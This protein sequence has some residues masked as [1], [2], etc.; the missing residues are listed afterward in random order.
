MLCLTT[1]KNLGKEPNNMWPTQNF[2]FSHK[3]LNLKKTQNY[4]S[5]RDMAFHIFT[6]GHFKQ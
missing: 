2:R 1:K 3:G 6:G 5:C 4:L